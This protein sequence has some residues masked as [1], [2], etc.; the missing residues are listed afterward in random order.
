MVIGKGQHKCSPDEYVFAALQAR[1]WHRWR[2]VCVSR[3]VGQ[4]QLSA[5]QAGGRAPHQHAPSLPHP[6]HLARVHTQIYLDIVNIFLML[7]NI[8]GIARS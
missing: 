6:H 3:G 8:I 7:L 1:K 4:Q 5:G 2:G